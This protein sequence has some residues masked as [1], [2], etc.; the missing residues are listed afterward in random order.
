MRSPIGPFLVVL[1]LATVV[2][3]VLLLFQ[4]IGLRSDLDATRAELDSLRSAVESREDG[5][6]EDDLIARLD[7]LEA[8]IRDWLIATGADG[9]FDESPGGSPGDTS[10]ADRLDEILRR[11]EA[12]DDRIDEICEGVPVC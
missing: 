5:V 7:E 12:L 11:L 9:G 3:L 4:T 1:G 8:G 10:V 6:S 2:V